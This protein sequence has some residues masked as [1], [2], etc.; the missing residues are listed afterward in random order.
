VIA[1]ARQGGSPWIF[2]IDPVELGATL[3]LRGLVFVEEV[4]EPDYRERYLDP[5][6]RELSIY[7]GERV[8]LARVA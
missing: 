8:V 3:A 1:L 4:W 5:I 6:G 2:G 7:E